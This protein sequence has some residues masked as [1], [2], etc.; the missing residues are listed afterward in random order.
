MKRA[1]SALMTAAVLLFG[2][3][4]VSAYV[5]ERVQDDQG[6][7]KQC[8]EEDSYGIKAPNVQVIFDRSRSMLEPSGV[9]GGPYSNTSDVTKEGQSDVGLVVVPSGDRNNPTGRDALSLSNKI[10]I[11]PYLWVANHSYNTLSKFNIK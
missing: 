2:T 9:G 10:E 7:W 1:G 6:N 8:D 5:F 4:S 3:A 11:P